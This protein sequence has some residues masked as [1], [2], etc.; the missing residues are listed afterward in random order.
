M[1]KVMCPLNFW[2]LVANSSRMI[3]APDYKVGTQVKM[4]FYKNSLVGGA[5]FYECFI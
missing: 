1:A 3:K 5:N 2:A 4:H